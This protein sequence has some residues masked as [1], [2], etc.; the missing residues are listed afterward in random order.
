MRADILHDIN[1]LSLSMS[2]ALAIRANALFF[3]KWEAS[4]DPAVLQVIHLILIRN[5]TSL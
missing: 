2:P 3:S 5:Y 1:V 4:V